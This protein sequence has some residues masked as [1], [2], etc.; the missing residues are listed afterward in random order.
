[1]N[2]KLV[3]GKTWQASVFIYESGND[4]DCTFFGIASTTGFIIKFF[5]KMLSIAMSQGKKIQIN[6]FL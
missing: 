3:T 1:M 4:N 2:E 6:I 5:F